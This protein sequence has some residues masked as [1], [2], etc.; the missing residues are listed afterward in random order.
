MGKLT[1]I[2]DVAARCD[3]LERKID[4]L[5]SFSHG[6]RATY[7]G[8]NRVLVKAVVADCNLAYLVEADDKLL[9]PWFT[10]TGTYET[11]LTDFFRSRNTSGQP[12]Y[13]CGCQFRLLCLSHVTLRARRPRDRH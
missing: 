8:N 11:E 5:E 10:I 3:R 9:S 2:L 7:V 1:S 12:L 4:R 13:R 6:A